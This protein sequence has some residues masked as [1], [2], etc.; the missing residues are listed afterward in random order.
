MNVE[1]C[2]VSKLIATGQYE[3]VV[4]CDITADMFVDEEAANMFEYVAHHAR[5]YKSTPSMETAKDD[6]PDFDFEHVQEPLEYVID[7][8]MT[9]VRKRMAQERVKDLAEAIGDPERAAKIELEFLEAA[10]HIAMSVPSTQVSRFSDIDQRAADYERRAREGDKPGIPFGFPTLDDYTGGIQ[11]HEFVTVSAFSGIGKST[12]LNAI[13]FN[14]WASDED[15]V[16]MYISL[17]MES[18]ALLSRFDA[19]VAGLN[20]KKLK[21]LNLDEESKEKWVKTAAQIK[22]RLKNRDILILDKIRSCTPDKVYAEMMKHDPDIVF[23]DYLSLMK[24]SQPNRTNSMWQGIMEITQDLK[25]TARTLGTPIVA[26]AQTNR[27]GKKEGADLDNIGYG[28]SIVQDSDIIIGLHADDEMKKAK[29]ME[30]RINKNRE[31]ALGKFRCVWDHENMEFREEQ[32]S[33]VFGKPGAKRVM[34]H[35]NLPDLEDEDEDEAPRRRPVKKP[36]RQ[37][38]TAKKA[39]PRPKK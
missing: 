4:A 27:S 29:R 23:L 11:P 12:L 1:K 16:S 21:Q 2:L 28:L 9:L 38:P 36:M 35:E 3:K 25:Q 5:R 34:P 18:Q 22:K 14:V 13:A 24:S 7:K 10:R 32:K 17:E 15:R 8:F 19:M 20:Y 30:I 33:D 6:N 31:G 39:R 37:K 26:A